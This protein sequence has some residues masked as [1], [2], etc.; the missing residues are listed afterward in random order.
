M[1]VPVEIIEIQ[2]YHYQVQALIVKGEGGGSRPCFGCLFKSCEK[3]LWTKLKLTDLAVSVIIQV[4][5][6]GNWA[7]IADFFN[8][9]PGLN[10][11]F[12]PAHG[13]VYIYLEISSP[14]F[15]TEFPSFR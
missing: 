13:N 3:F 9:H 12:L 8:P 4:M 7:R 14:R 2:T 11:E 1:I 15:S 5:L 6:G 10:S